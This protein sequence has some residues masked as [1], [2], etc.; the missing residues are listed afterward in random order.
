MVTWVI[1]YL[2]SNTSKLLQTYTTLVV[3]NKEAKG[4]CSQ[5][6]SRNWKVVTLLGGYSLFQPP[7]C[8]SLRICLHSS[9]Q[10]GFHR[11]NIHTAK[12]SLSAFPASETPAQAA[13]TS[14]AQFQSLEARGGLTPLWVLYFPDTLAAKPHAGPLATKGPSVCVC[15]CV[16]ARFSEEG[17]A[18]AKRHP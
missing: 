12:P 8:F 15:V 6:R 14:Q 18:W 9:L 4:S 1:S 13:T 11:F 16:R 7:L 2:Q 3:N 10:T 17:E 5:T